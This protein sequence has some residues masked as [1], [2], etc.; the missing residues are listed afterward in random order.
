VRVD[1]GVT[2]RAANGAW[3]PV[4]GELPRVEVDAANDAS[5]ADDVDGLLPAVSLAPLT[6][7]TVYVAEVC[8]RTG[9]R[10]L[11]STIEQL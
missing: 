9:F 10:A 6:R 8:S 5:A 3:K 11:P 4:Y 2:R 7:A 1:T